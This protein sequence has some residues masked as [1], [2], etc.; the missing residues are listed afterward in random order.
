MDGNEIQGKKYILGM[1]FRDLLEK[2]QLEPVIVREKKNIFDDIQTGDTVTVSMMDYFSGV[3]YYPVSIRDAVLIERKQLKDLVE[4]VERLE[5][6]NRKM[7]KLLQEKGKNTYSLK[8]KLASH[9]II[10]MDA[11]LLG[12]SN[13]EIERT[14]RYSRSA[15]SRVLAISVKP[16]MTEDEMNLAR[17]TDLK[18]L[19]EIYRSRDK[20]IR[21]PDFD[22]VE[23]W[24]DRKVKAKLEHH[25]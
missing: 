12:K 5:N 25:R 11:A 21:Y 22:I 2:G 4:K 18:R 15:I 17:Q 7:K 19:S 24:Y 8:D 9:S 3:P 1:S 20:S 13:K 6:D 14:R 10:L 16:G 23:K